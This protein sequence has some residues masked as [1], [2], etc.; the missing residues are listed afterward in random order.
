MTLFHTANLEMCLCAI[1]I[2]IPGLD[3]GSHGERSKALSGHFFLTIIIL[4]MLPSPPGFSL[5]TKLKNRQTSHRTKLE[6]RV[7]EKR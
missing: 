4:R 2:P 1:T 6:F 7:G 3:L 5:I